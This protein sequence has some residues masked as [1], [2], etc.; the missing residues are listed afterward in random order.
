MS[1]SEYWAKLD[2][3]GYRPLNYYATSVWIGFSD[4]G[5]EFEWYFWD[6]DPKNAID[7]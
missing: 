6:I 7:V 2:I 3:S 1:N 4:D 5:E